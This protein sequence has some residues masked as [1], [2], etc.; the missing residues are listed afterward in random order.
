MPIDVIRLGSARPEREELRLGTIRH[1]P[2]G[3]PRDRLAKDGWYDVWLPALAPSAAL[4]QQGR[5]ATTDRDW[6]TF[7]RR[8]RKEMDAPAARHLLAFLA[9][10]SHRTDLAVGCTCPDEARCHRSVLREL[11]L[12]KGASVRGGARDVR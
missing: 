1:P 7:V 3:V 4:V 11:L 2:R 9:A 8:Y 6:A 10:L 5:G 12:E